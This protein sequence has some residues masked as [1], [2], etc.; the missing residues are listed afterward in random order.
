M[1][2]KIIKNGIIAGLLLFTSVAVCDTPHNKT[3]D[4]IQY[5]DVKFKVDEDN[6]VYVN[7]K[8]IKGKTVNIRFFDGNSGLIHTEKIKKNNAVLRKYNVNDIQN[9]PFS[10][11]VIDT[12]MIKR[13]FNQK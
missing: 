3:K 4:N 11:E 10:F 8:K 9:N 1:K 12:Q 2:K 13:K 7:F 5:I 6:I